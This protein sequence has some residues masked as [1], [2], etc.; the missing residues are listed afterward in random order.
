MLDV[1]CVVRR[2]ERRCAARAGPHPVH[3]KPYAC[4]MCP[5]PVQRQEP[6]SPARAIPRRF[7]RKSAVPPH[8]RTHTG[9]KPYACSMCP[10]W[11]A[12]KS[13]V[14]RHERAHTRCMISP[15]HAR[16]APA[17]SATRAMFPRTSHVPPHERSHAG[18]KHYGCFFC[19]KSFT[20]GR[21]KTEAF[22]PA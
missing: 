1:P 10:V 14:A 2:Q 18:E 20:R 4:S 3:D 9:E 12:D 21:K 6:H 11:F 5:P 13:A 16:C 17:G 19:D 7:S 15:T 22:M 8:E